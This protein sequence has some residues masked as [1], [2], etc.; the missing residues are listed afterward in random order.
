MNENTRDGGSTAPPRQS[1]AVVQ[2]VQVRQKLPLQFQPV[3]EV[4]ADQH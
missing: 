1:L 4:A 3:V 2:Q